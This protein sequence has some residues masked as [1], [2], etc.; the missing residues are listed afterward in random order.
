MM[1][2]KNRFFLDYYFQNT[3]PEIFSTWS[4]LFPIFIIIQC[5]IINFY[6]FEESFF[7]LAIG[8]RIGKKLIAPITFTG[9]CN[10]EVLLG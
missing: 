5:R 7:Q 8:G 4:W 1:N 10:K 9:G 2:L 6:R 3:F